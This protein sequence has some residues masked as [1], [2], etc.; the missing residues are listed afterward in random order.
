M[1]VLIVGVNGQDGSLLAEN[2][3][4]RGYTVLGICSVNGLIRSHGFQT[5]CTDLSDPIKSKIIFDD[6]RPDRIFHLAAVHSSSASP[7]LFPDETLQRIYAC[8]VMITKNILDWQRVNSTSKSIVGLSSQMY[9]REISGSY[10]TES[11]VVDPRNYYAETKVEAFSLIKK[12]RDNYGV[13]SSGAILFNHTSSRSKAEF[14]FPQLVTKISQL[15]R[16]ATTEITVRDPDAEL[17]ISDARELIDGLIRMAEIEEPTDFI[18]ARGSSVKIHDLISRT[19]RQLGF[20]GVYTIKREVGDFQSAPTVTGNPERALRLL[21]WKAINPP[22]QI[23]STMI[24]EQHE[25]DT[26]P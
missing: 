18:F 13:H 15:L 19:I 5:L 14:L 24:R 21:N 2:Y 1:R 12:Y 25:D 11:S 16:G 17:D 4:A 22:E 20:D 6:F 8:N 9:S 23:L 7:E 3:L 26:L 10:I